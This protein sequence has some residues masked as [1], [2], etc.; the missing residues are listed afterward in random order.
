[1]GQ[2]GRT[3]T[4][5][6]V[7]LEL[8]RERT[9]SQASLAKRLEVTARTVR[10][11]VLDLTSAG[12]PIEREEDHPHVYYSLARDWIPNGAVIANNELRELVR[13]LSRIPSAASRRDAIA[14]R[15][16]PGEPWTRISPAL[17]DSLS[18]P[19]LRRLELIEDSAVERCAVEVSYLSVM[20]GVVEQRHL[21]CQR[22]AYHDRPIRFLAMCHRSN[23]LKWFVLDRVHAA[24]LDEGT[25][26]RSSDAEAVDDLV[27]N[28]LFDFHSS[29]TP[30]ECRFV[31][32][33]P[34]HR[35]FVPRLG[36]R[37]RV[38]PHGESVR[39]TIQTS[40]LRVLARALVGLGAAVRIESPELRAEVTRIAQ[41][42]LQAT[43]DQG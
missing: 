36:K 30:V 41:A 40:A 11:C 34:E 35:W 39:V 8:M 21:S 23:T 32:H 26:Y 3:E 9:I 25:P 10:A 28:T 17:E 16:G 31:I 20:R 22:I 43:E 4:I 38:E 18:P 13:I 12:M 7:I 2:R 33:P 6:Q 42:A 37:A 24:Y 14:A 19:E 29:E 15:L 1:M 5:A 27:Q